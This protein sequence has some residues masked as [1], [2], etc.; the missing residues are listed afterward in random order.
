MGVVYHARYLVW[1]D[2][3]RTEYLRNAGTAYS[4]LEKSGILLVV[5][6]LQIRYRSP[7]KYDELITVDCWVREAASRRVTF[8]YAV[9]GE[10]R[11][12]LLA[13]AVTEMI[14][15]NSNFVPARLPGEVAGLLSPINDPVEL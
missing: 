15:L 11:R 12:A 8:G 7:A 5:G 14:S 1:L 10:D 13:T 2:M 6:N 9:W 4:K 3:A